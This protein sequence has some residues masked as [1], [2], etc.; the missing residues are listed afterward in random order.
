MVILLLYT[1]VS[2]IDMIDITIFIVI[3]LIKQDMLTIKSGIGVIGLL[4]VLL[5]LVLTALQERPNFVL[6]LHLHLILLHPFLFL[7]FPSHHTLSRWVTAQDSKEEVE[8]KET[9]TDTSSSK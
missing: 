6:H 7:L 8:N 3:F 9:M 4:V 2:T 1:I 5:H